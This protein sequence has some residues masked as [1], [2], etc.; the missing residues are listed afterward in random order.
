[1][2]LAAAVA[3]FAAGLIV[4]LA[5]SEL[6]VRTI[7][8]LGAR[9]SL[10]GG[11]VG[12]LTA[13]GADAPEISSAVTALILGAKAIG[14]G[15][16]VGSNLFNLAALLGLSA[17]LAGGLTFRRVVMLIDGG[18]GLIVLAIVAAL[19]AGWLSASL[20]IALLAL[21]GAPYLAI[22]VLGPAA[23]DGAFLP[24]VVRRSA[25][26]VAA[27]VHTS[28]ERPAVVE[29]SLWPAWLLLPALAVIVGGSYAMVDA[30]I[31]LSDRFHVS[32]RFMGTVVLAILTSLPNAY[33]AVRLALLR[34]G[35]AVVSETFNS[36]TIN[37]VA[38][39][40]V[41][42]LLVRTAVLSR[43]TAQDLIWVLGLSVAAL[44]LGAPWGA[45]TRSR[46]LALIAGY[47]IY[48]AVQT[49]QGWA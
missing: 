40:A 2:T 22:Q 30:A 16:I 34:H 4:S 49:V 8:W 17:L 28:S 44:A 21:A 41:P 19:T 32:D 45:M 33:A 13:L 1:M 12:L 18:F 6:M 5:A 23:W 29:R 27:Q 39:I 7:T 15:V 48:L 35:A 42:A 37:L 25:A 9:L 26:W 46:G 3:L 43:G 10:S 20:T 31:T 24:P 11:T 14:V 36:N 38:G 47:G